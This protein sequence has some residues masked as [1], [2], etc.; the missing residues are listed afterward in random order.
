MHLVESVVGDVA[1]MDAAAE[2]THQPGCGGLA[3]DGGA[4][5]VDADEPEVGPV[6]AQGADQ[7]RAVASGADA[8]HQDVQVVQLGAEFGGEGGISGG[9]VRVVVLVR[10]VGA[11]EFGEQFA[12]PGEPCGLPAALRGGAVGEFQADAVGAQQLPHG[13]LQFAVAD[14]HDGMPERLPGEGEPDAEGAGGGLHHR[15][16]GRQFAAVPG[17]EQHRHGGPC[18]H[19]ARGEPFQLGPE[20]GVRAG[21]PGGDPD[22]GRTA[23]QVEQLPSRGGSYGG[24]GH[25]RPPSPRYRW[26]TPGPPSSQ[27][28]G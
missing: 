25:R 5:G 13:R 20:P 12:Q 17:A 19:A 27:K 22:D 7:A 3:E 18:L 28:K 26:T 21:Q 10:P 6:A 14:Q 8:A 16:A 23:D 24:R 1:R 4:G 9:V 11:G 15:C 2:A